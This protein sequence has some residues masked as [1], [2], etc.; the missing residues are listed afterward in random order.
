MDPEQRYRKQYSEIE[1]RPG[2]KAIR[3]RI[4]T[5]RNGVRTGSDKGGRNTRG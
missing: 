3:F 1:V 2:D 4:G 5:D